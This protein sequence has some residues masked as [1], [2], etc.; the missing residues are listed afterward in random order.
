M[1][2]A[3]GFPPIVSN[4]AR[5]LILGSLPGQRSLAEQRYYAHPQNAFWTFVFQIIEQPLPD[6]YDVRVKRL[7]QARIAL[8]DVIASGNREGSLD[9]NIVHSTVAP[10][11]I[12]ELVKQLPDLKLVAF[13]GKAAEAVFRRSSRSF[14]WENDLAHISYLTLP[15][16]SPANAQM[17]KEDKLR[18]WLGLRAWL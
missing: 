15:S 6:D 3:E 8:W 13:N 11:A 9:S 18:A 4:D 7:S 1:T 12:P 16:T 2:R 17:S 10:N 14:A 5:I